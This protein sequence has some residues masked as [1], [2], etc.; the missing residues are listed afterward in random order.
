[1][2]KRIIELFKEADDEDKKI[3][4]NALKTLANDNKAFDFLIKSLEDSNVLMRP[5]SARLLGNIGD[6]RA[7]EPL[8]KALEDQN[9][10]V[11][12]YVAEALGN[13]GDSRAVEPLIRMISGKEPTVIF[14]IAEALG[15]IGDSRAVEPLIEI[16]KQFDGDIRASAAKALGKIGDPRA[17][18]PLIGTLQDEWFAARVTAAQSLGEIGDSRAINSLIEAL[19]DHEKGVAAS[20]AESLGKFND[21]Y[22]KDALSKAVLENHIIP[23]NGGGDE[24]LRVSKGLLK[25]AAINDLE[26]SPS[27]SKGNKEKKQSKGKILGKLSIM[28]GATILLI[29][30]IIDVWASYV[31]VDFLAQGFFISGSYVDLIA[32]LLVTLFWV[33][34]WLVATHNTL[35]SLLDL[36]ISAPTDED[37]KL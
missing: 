9:S 23:I 30:I 10:N 25:K 15:N 26:K 13:I 29:L 14:F 20:A 1:M 21:S 37:E 31:G 11:I 24:V 35:I 7:V 4:S 27:S 36:F 34:I 18:N 32:K 5:G 16:L 22:A 33:S 17:V 2:D 6:S 19:K 8:L 3:R 12:L 28:F